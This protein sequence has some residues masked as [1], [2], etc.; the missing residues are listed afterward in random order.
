MKLFHSAQMYLFDKIPQIYIKIILASS[1]G[2]IL[3]QGVA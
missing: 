1:K 3:T 2:Q